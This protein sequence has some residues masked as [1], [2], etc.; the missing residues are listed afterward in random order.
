M[1]NSAGYRPLG[2]GRRIGLWL[3]SLLIAVAFFSVFLSLCLTVAGSNGFGLVLPVFRMT[4]M[5]ALPIWCLCIPLVIAMKNAEGWR[6]WTV[7]L[8]GSFIGPLLVG[9]WF[10]LLELGGANQQP[11]TWQG[12]SFS[13]RTGSSLAGMLF[14]LIVGL[15][16]TSLYLLSIR[17]LHR[18]E[19]LPVAEPPGSLGQ[20]AG[21]L[22]KSP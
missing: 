22:H 12:E 18:R 13:G 5:C 9:L 19:G 20:G 3:V 21:P 1:L 16:T 15:L 14:A 6:G 2:T 7:L 8:V 11:I 4:M 10:L 17:L